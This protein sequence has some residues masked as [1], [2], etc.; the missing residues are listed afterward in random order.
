M[1]S[2]SVSDKLGLLSLSTQRTHFLKFTG[3]H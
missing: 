3:C 1:K 2:S